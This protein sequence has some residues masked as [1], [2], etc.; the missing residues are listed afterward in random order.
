MNYTKDKKLLVITEVFAPEEFLINDLVFH[1]KN[2]GFSV[3]VLTRNP[4]YPAGQIFPGYSNKLFQREVMDGVT[5]H[6]VQ[7]IPGYKRNKHLKVMNY[8][9]NMK[10]AWLWA[11]MNGKKFDAVFVCQ[12]GPLTFS[13]TGVLI[14]KL[15]RKKMTIW[16]Q[17]VWPETVFAYGLAKKGL[18]RLILEKF[19]GW[20]YTN[21]DHVTVSCPGFIPM[22][23]KY[24]PD[25]MV[26]YIPQWSLTSRIPAVEN[27]TLDI[28][29]PGKFNFVFAGNIGKVQNLENAILGF[30]SFRKTTGHNETWFN[31][32]GDGSHLQYLKEMVND[33]NIEN[34][35]F[36]GRV[37]SSE[38]PIYYAKADVLVISLENTPVFNLTIPAK[39]QSYLNAEKPI[40]GII[41]G[42]VA[43]LIE[44]HQLGWV[45][46]PGNIREIAGKFEEITASSAE[47]LN[48]K[49]LNANRLLTEEFNR[50][51]LI[52]K[53]THLIFG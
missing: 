5:V 49:T 34:V 44:K 27:N 2:E 10:L 53:F 45:A 18:S 28:E 3:S 30:D 46:S 23:N 14:R 13:S 31:L 50:A 51:T 9:W 6:R 29:F 38:M 22:I 24:C 11:I 15:Y 20:V 19:V 52:E 21:C 17:D 40:Y 35:S 37:K 43:G 32:I 25:Q 12:T 36:L 26:T 4:S 8:L 42:E 16:I 41:S 47:T 39:F 48:G 7:F 1:W 33:K